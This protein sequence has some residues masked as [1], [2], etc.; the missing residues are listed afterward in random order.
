M[1]P[2]RCDDASMPPGTPI[3]E[4]T[5]DLVKA[6]DALG[7]PLTVAAR[8]RELLEQTGF[9][10]VVERRLRWPTNQWP[11]DRRA[12]E[13]GLWTFGCLDGGLEGL[14]LALFTRGLGLSAEQTLARCVQVRKDLRNPRIH[15]YFAV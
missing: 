7:R 10:A 8:F 15:A 5:E 9:E 13:L 1:F 6:A 12:K 14:T 3:A 4:W 11:R 2:I